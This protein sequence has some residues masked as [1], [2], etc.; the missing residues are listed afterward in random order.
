MTVLMMRMSIRKVPGAFRSEV[1]GRSVGPSSNGDPPLISNAIVMMMVMLMMVMMVMVM[2]MMS[3]M[4]VMVM[5]M[6]TKMMTL[7][8][9]L[10]GFGLLSQMPLWLH[11]CCI[12]RVC[13]LHFFG[14]TLNFYCS[15]LYL[16][17]DM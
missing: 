7:V 12:F 3:M 17:L 10:L 8:E 9:P 2:M 14:F 13:A 16:Y 1:Q 5:M 6:M 4:R 15:V 11:C